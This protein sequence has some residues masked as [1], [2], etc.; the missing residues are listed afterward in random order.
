MDDT[1][2]RIFQ[3]YDSD[4]DELKLKLEKV[5]ENIVDRA[6]FADP[7]GESLL[8][9]FEAQLSVVEQD[10]VTKMEEI[11]AAFSNIEE[12]GAVTAIFSYQA[13]IV[14][15]LNETKSTLVV[16]KSLET[17]ENISS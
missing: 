9:D 8:K 4:L 3:K 16:K 5:M 11:A 17:I 15:I 10:I 14:K 6:P 12:F 1:A 2:G 13:K 7:D